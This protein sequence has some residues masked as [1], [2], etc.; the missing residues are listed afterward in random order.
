MEVFVFQ[1]AF[2]NVLVKNIEKKKLY[3]KYISAIHAN[4]SESS[5][6]SNFPFRGTRV[7]TRSFFYGIQIAPSLVFCVVFYRSLFLLFVWLLIVIPPIV[8]DV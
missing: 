7:H 8:R 2:L 3:P 6:C 5:T 4:V 1:F